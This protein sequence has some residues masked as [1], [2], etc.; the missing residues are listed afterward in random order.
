MS[1]ADIKEIINSPI[2]DNNH[3]LLYHICSNSLGSIINFIM[4]V[5]KPSEIVNTQDDDGNTPLHLLCSRVDDSKLENVNCFKYIN[6]WTSFF[7]C[8]TSQ[9]SLETFILVFNF[10]SN[11]ADFTIKNN[12][13]QTIDELT[14]NPIIHNMYYNIMTNKDSPKSQETN[15]S[16]KILYRNSTTINKD[17]PNK[18]VWNA[19]FHMKDSN[20]KNRTLL[21]HICLG[22]RLSAIKLLISNGAE[23]NQTTDKGVFSSING[24]FTLMDKNLGD[25]SSIK[26]YVPSGF[27]SAD[28]ISVDD[29]KQNPLLSHHEKKLLEETEKIAEYLAEEGAALN[30]YEASFYCISEILYKIYKSKK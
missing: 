20:N 14:E 11:F 7:S 21:H 28:N 26:I 10:L 9:P 27:R 19:L 15:S 16:Q 13:G 3:S 22:D 17:I 25:Y 29:L 5:S 18:E 30:S 1:S 4:K 12:K 8:F 24:L 2:I 23:V 6:D